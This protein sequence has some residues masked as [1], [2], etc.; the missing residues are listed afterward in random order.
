MGLMP[1]EAASP[2]AE[3]PPN[4]PTRNL[5]MICRELVAYIFS[6]QKLDQNERRILFDTMQEIQ[7]RAQAGGGIGMGGETPGT[8]P[9]PPAA[10][11]D[12]TE[13]MHSS[14]E[15]EPRG[16]PDDEGY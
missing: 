15:N 10:D 7:L 12:A 3:A 14:P 11:M 4:R 1:E 5:E 8:E 2:V 13:D 16:G 9:T 6:D